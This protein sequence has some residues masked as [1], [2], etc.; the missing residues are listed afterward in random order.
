MKGSGVIG[1]LP[2]DIHAVS[3]AD[4]AYTHAAYLPLLSVATVIR[5]GGTDRGSSTL[6]AGVSRPACNRSL[7]GGRGPPLSTAGA[8]MASDAAMIRE[9]TD[10]EVGPF[11]S[12]NYQHDARAASFPTSVW[13]GSAALAVHLVWGL[14]L[15]VRCFDA[16]WRVH[17][18]LW[19]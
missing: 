16:G 19:G 11:G 2:G 1:L 5:Q 6:V 7:L 3:H 17:R 13:V 12:I 18:A 10:W 9:P 4:N 8:V 15:A 14:S